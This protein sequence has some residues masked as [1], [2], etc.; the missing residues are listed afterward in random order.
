MSSSTQAKSDTRQKVFLRLT[1]IRFWLVWAVPLDSFI[2]EK[3]FLQKERGL[4]WWISKPTPVK[5]GLCYP[6]HGVSLITRSK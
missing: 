6:E 5:I 3:F 2:L 4:D 1:H